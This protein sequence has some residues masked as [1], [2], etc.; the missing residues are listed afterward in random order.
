MAVCTV[1]L[2]V[3]PQSRH[4]IEFSDNASSFVEGAWRWARFRA[5]P[6][7]N[8][9]ARL[10]RGLISLTRR[11]KSS[12]SFLFSAETP[13]ISALRSTRSYSSFVAKVRL[14]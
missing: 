11:F 6:L 10:P 5:H 3:P 4:R 12:T 7:I 14:S 1:I 2:P 8:L 9:R 13:E